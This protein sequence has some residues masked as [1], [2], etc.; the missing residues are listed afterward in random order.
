LSKRLTEVALP[1]ARS[2]T[3]GTSRTQ[4]K[5]STSPTYDISTSGL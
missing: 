2:N 3:I 5:I 1:I 4:D